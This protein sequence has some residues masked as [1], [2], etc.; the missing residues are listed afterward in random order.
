MYAIRRNVQNTW[1]EVLVTIFKEENRSL[2][3]FNF[4]HKN[5]CIKICDLLFKQYQQPMEYLNDL[6]EV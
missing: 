2:Y 6:N 4:A 5:I 3:F 1:N